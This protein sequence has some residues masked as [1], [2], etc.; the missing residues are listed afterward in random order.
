MFRIGE[1]SKLG[2]VSSRM[3]RHYDKLGL[4][5]PSSTDEWTGYR[6][7]TIEQLPRLHRIIAL[8]DL[9]LSLEQIGLLLDEGDELPLEQL[10]GMLRMREADLAQELQAKQV[11]LAQVKARLQQLETEGEPS[12]YEVLVKPIPSQAVA[13]I[14]QLVPSVQEMN[15]YCRILYEQLYLE[16]DKQKIRPLQPEITLYHNEEYEEREL[17]VETAVAIAPQEIGR[18]SPNS[19]LLARELPAADLAAALIYQ[20]SFDDM[21]PAVLALLTYVG[22]HAHIVAGPLREIHLSGPAHEDG[23]VVEEVVIEL[24]VPIQPLPQN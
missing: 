18:I 15:Y 6:Y 10:Q 19:H 3:L 24:Q 17:D 23:Q 22:T 20:G 1:F 14:R 8:K 16:L 11:Q 2:Q 7:Y 5:N 12:P 9:G 13:S 21:L 4:L